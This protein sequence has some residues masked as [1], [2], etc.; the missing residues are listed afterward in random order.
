M[1]IERRQHT[2]NRIVYGLFGVDFISTF[3]TTG[4]PVRVAAEVKGFDPSTVVGP[5]EARRLDR[6]IVLAVAALGS[7]LDEYVAPDDVRDHIE[8]CERDALVHL[9][10]ALDSVRDELDDALAEPCDLP[11]TPEAKRMFELAARR[12]R[13]V[14]P[15]QMLA[16][17]VRH[18]ARARRFLIELDVPV[19]TLQARLTR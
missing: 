9:G 7:V 1:R 2:A 4:F 14:T 16:T 3:D 6:N 8:L 5:K 17:L 18:S 10:I 11:I 15:D 13:Y 12:R 19:G